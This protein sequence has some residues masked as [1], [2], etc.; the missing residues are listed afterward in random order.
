MTFDERAKALLMQMTLDEK[1]GL[2][3]G[4]DFWHTNGIERLGVPKIMLTDGPH[5][6]RRQAGD[7]DHL[8]L[9]KSVPSTCFPA[10]ATVACSWDTALIGQMG[11]KIGEEAACEGVQVVLGPAINIKRNPLCGRNFEYLSEDP[12]LAGKLAAAYIQGM[13]QHGVSSCPKHFAVNNQERLRMTI[14][15]VVDER[16]LR[17]IYL[18][19]FEYAVKEGGAKSI[20]SSYNRVNGDYAN[21]NRHLLCDILREEWGFDGVVVTDWGGCNDR[22]AGLLCGNQLE[23]PGSMGETDREIVQAVRDGVLTEERLDEILLPLVKLTLETSA[24]TR[25]GQSYPVE[26]HHSFARTVAEQSMVLLKNEN[27]LLP[28]SPETT[29]AVI[30]AFAQK[31]R[32]QGAGSS[33]IN[34]TRLESPLEELRKAPLNIAGFA[35]GFTRDG[36]ADDEKRRVAVELAKTVSVVVLFMGLD[37]STEIEGLDRADMSLPRVQLELLD[38][39]HAVNPRVVVVLSGGSPVET[40]WDNK[41]VAVLNG[42]LGGQAGGSA[43]AGLLCGRVNPSGKLA[44]SYPTS[45]D[46]LP[47]AKYY[48]DGDKATE[49]R[50]SIFVGY[51]YFDKAGLAVKYPFGHGLSYTSFEYGALAYSDG[52]V[53]FTVKNTGGRAGAEVAQLYIAAEK[54]AVARP[55]K[56]LK[57]FA[58]VWLDA[59]ESRRVELATDE[60]AFAFYDVAQSRWRVEKGI[61]RLMVGASCT[62]IRQTIAIEVEG[63]TVEAVDRAGMPDYFAGSVRNVDDAQYARLLGRPLQQRYWNPAEPVNIN[64]SLREGALHRGTGRAL[65][66]IAGLLEWLS[67]KDVYKNAAVKA[68]YDMPFRALARMTDG[69]FTTSMAQAIVSMINDGFWTGLGLFIKAVGSKK[70]YIIKGRNSR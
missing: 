15:S 63:E 24:A 7:A 11:G 39:L 50:E 62:D 61:Y 17:E 37:E 53:S 51:R 29:V 38:A 36:K 57:G 13:Q 35:E 40:G 22:V 45:Y 69:A 56:E 49:Y 8:G 5:G 31:A 65:Y 54:S 14:D 30:G 32:Y 20:M 4:G 47:N 67:R 10:G 52:K 16:A 34:P 44:E 19:P 68:A 27:K 46:D 9:N 6:L 64:S 25:A 21:E 66:R 70:Q 2:C 55:A 60:R 48:L 18:T 33:I 3:S 43:V 23:M 42:Y 28:L 59:G 41:A 12:Y 26:E 1:A 58:K